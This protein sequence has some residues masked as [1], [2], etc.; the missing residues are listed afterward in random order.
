MVQ[1]TQENIGTVKNVLADKG[2]HSGRELKACEALGVTTFISPKEHSSSKKNG[3]AMKD[4][5]YDEEQDHYTCPAGKD[6]NTNGRWYNKKLDASGRKS[7]KVKHYKTKACE[8]CTVRDHCT[9]NK[10]GRFIERTE[11]QE[12]TVR[13]NQRV[14][15]NPEY[16][17]QRQQIIE[18]Y[19][20]KLCTPQFGTLKRHRH[21]DYL[22]TRGKEKVMGEVYLSFIMYNLRRTTSI[23]GFSELLRRLKACFMVLF[24]YLWVS[25]SVRPI[26]SYKLSIST[27]RYHGL[28]V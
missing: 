2:Y 24:S 9:R 11:Y 25:N 20:D 18:H 14:N 19:F 13:N 26:T 6:L 17:R 8:N 1:K 16:Y 3:Y 15:A 21:F 10:R 23:F 12:Y 7:Y 5:V 28:C 4:F 27:V 22:L